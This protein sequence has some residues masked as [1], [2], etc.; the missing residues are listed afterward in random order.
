MNLLKPKKKS[1]RIAFTHLSMLIVCLDNES[2][3]LTQTGTRIRFQF[4]FQTLN[5]PV[6]VITSSVYDVNF[7]L[8]NEQFLE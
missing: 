3:G 1:S 5:Y 6:P 7:T 8:S 4:F 2:N